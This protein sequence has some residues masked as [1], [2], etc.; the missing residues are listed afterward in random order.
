MAQELLVESTTLGA[1]VRCR[2]LRDVPVCQHSL[3]YISMVLMFLNFEKTDYRCYV[4]Y[5]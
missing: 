5:H 4:C 1:V 2:S 3:T